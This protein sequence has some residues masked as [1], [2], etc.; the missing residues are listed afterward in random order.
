MIVRESLVLTLGYLVEA[1]CLSAVSKLPFFKNV[2]HLWQSLRSKLLVNC[3]GLDL[4]IQS[5]QVLSAPNMRVT[6][7]G[8]NRDRKIILMPL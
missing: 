4:N 6:S 3:G 8:C 7:K 1:F 5:A 2:V